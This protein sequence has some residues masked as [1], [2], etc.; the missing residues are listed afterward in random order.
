MFN[1]VHIVGW[2]CRR[3]SVSWE[4]DSV[5]EPI[6]MPAYQ[7]VAADL[8]EL[9]AAG[10]LPV[11]SAIPSTNELTR[12]YEVSSTVA[13]AAVNTLRADGLVVG[14]PGKGVFVRA[15]PEAVAER[16]LSIE[17]LQRQVA[18]LR[19]TVALLET[20]VEELEAGRGSSES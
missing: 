5:T 17:E 4:D 9:I 3:L 13:R 11:G 10:D 19:R 20:R 14:Q 7:Q 6:G 2:A 15:T 18:E 1:I 8:R 12:R 16:S